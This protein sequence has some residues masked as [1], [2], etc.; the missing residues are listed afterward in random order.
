MPKYTYSHFIIV[1]SVEIEFLIGEDMKNVIFWD[2]IP[3]NPVEVHR[4]FGVETS[5]YSWFTLRRGKGSC[6]FLRNGDELLSDYNLQTR[7]H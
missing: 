5:S 6:V 4:R 1:K 7:V 3:C 2:K